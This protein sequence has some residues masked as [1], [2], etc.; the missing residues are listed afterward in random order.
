M[1]Y[2]QDQLDEISMSAPTTVC[3]IRDNWFQSYEI[4]PEQF[5]YARCGKDQLTGGT[6]Q[7]NAAITRAILEGTEQGP[8]RQAVCLNA[9]AALYIGGRAETMEAGVKLAEALLDSG[10]AAAK[11]A[12][13]VRRSNG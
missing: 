10:K 6:P 12:E 1:V 3:E 8:K 9:G 11:L 4:T 13:V 7:E 5:G 2:G